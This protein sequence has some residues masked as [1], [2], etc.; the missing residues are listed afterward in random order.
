MKSKTKIDVV[1]TYGNFMKSTRMCGVNN[2]NLKV[3][4]D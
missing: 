4:V 2:L 1:K 3:L